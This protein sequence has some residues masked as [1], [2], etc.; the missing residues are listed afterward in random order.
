MLYYIFTFNFFQTSFVFDQLTLQLCQIYET[1]WIKVRTAKLSVLRN[2]AAIY[3]T[4][5]E[6]SKMRVRA[7]EQKRRGILSPSC[8]LRALYKNKTIKLTNAFH[9]G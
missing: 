8:S 4:E 6:I 9:A 2:L 7:R 5:G 1:S 3:R